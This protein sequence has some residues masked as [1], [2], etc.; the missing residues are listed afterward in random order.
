MALVTGTPLGQINTQDDLY[1][2]TAPVVFFQQRDTVNHLN[3]PDGDG[4]YWGLSGTV[5]RPVFEL[6]CVDTVVWAGQYELNAI[7]CDT[8]GDTGAIQKMT[9][10]DLTFNLKTL[11]PLATLRHILRGGAVT[12]TA[13]ATE[14][15]GIGQPNNNRFYRA[16]LPT[17][18]DED[19]GDY[20]AMTIHKCQYVDSWSLAFA[21]GT[22]S[23]L[24]LTLRGFADT[25]LPAAQLFATVIRADPSAI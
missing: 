15:M 1:V 4:F 11:F 12:T 16:Y 24:G 17:V 8:V 5:A 19:T 20:L 3:N 23:T 7:R 9:S 14:K 10:L 21:Y 25:A 13:G 2:D 18:Y 6:R 22:P